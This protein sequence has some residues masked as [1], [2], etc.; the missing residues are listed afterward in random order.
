MT[1]TD[2]SGSKDGPGT[3]RDAPGYATPPAYGSDSNG[4][5]QSITHGLQTTIEGSEYNQEVAG[6]LRP[7]PGP[8][9]ATI[10]KRSIT[11]GLELP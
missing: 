10:G 11:H 5:L 7:N 8:P 9:Q 1:I 6:A 3:S 4:G 2:T